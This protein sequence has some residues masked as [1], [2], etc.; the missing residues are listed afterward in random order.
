MGAVGADV[1]VKPWCCGASS[2]RVRPSV[3]IVGDS[4]AVGGVGPVEEVIE[5]FSFDVSEFVN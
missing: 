2:S 5:M 3:V 1:V 4:G